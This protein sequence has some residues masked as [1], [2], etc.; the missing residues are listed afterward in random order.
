M[1]GRP[2]EPSCSPVNERGAEPGLHACHDPPIT[3]SLQGS[4]R[5]TGPTCE[6][7][8]RQ[9]VYTEGSIKTDVSQE[10]KT[11]WGEG[12]CLQSKLR[13][14]DFNLKQQHNKSFLNNTNLFSKP[15]MFYFE[16]VS[17][18]LIIHN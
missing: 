2:A 6:L 11:A 4:I 13:T 18:D 16:S 15:E 8:M 10:Y 12:V 17:T 1:T 5:G 14:L 3:A 7:Y 9:A